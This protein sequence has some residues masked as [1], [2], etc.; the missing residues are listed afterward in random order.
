MFFASQRLKWVKIDTCYVL[1]FVLSYFR[2][3]SI[4]DENPAWQ[5]HQ[6]VFVYT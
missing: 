1:N 2:F 6:F 5:P 3:P 4:F